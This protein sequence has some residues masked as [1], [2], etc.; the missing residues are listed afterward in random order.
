M[1]QARARPRLAFGF[2]KGTRPVVVFFLVLGVPLR[3]SIVCFSTTTFARQVPFC[4][5]QQRVP[6]DFPRII[7]ESKTGHSKIGGEI[8][9]RALITRS[10]STASSISVMRLSTEPLRT[11]SLF[12]RAVYPSIHRA[13]TPEG[14]RHEVW[15]TWVCTLMLAVPMLGPVGLVL[16]VWCHTMIQR[17]SSDDANRNNCLR[18]SR[19]GN[20]ADGSIRAISIFAS[21]HA[22]GI[23]GLSFIAYGGCCWV[24]R[25]STRLMGSRYC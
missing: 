18:R 11:R 22:V 3:C 6:A 19:A 24:I 7:T 12:V 17:W 25:P 2:D 23:H 20:P 21:C 13:E 9:I 15:R 4:I 1:S 10:T 14:L 5:D 8:S 16:A